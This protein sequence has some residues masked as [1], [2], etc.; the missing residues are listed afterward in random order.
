MNQ[1]L[2]TILSLLNSRFN[3]ISMDYDCTNII[4]IKFI[5]YSSWDKIKYTF[6][7]NYFLILIKY[8]TCNL[9]YIGNQYVPTSN[10]RDKTNKSR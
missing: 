5:L 7:Q 10:T 6:I 4:H 3:I 1:T 8:Y 2:N 9:K